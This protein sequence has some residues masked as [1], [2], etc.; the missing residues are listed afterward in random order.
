MF[1]WFYSSTCPCSPPAKDWVEYRLQWLCDEFDDHVFNGRPLVLPTAQFFPDPY[2]D[3][4]DCIRR[5]M[6]RVCGYMDVD[7]DLVDLEFVNAENA[8]WFV[9]EAGKYVPKAGGTYEWLD[10][11][12]VISL[13]LAETVDLGGMVATLSHEL[14]HARLLGEER[15]SGEEYDHELLTD[16]T[17][18]F[19][20][21]GT[22]RANSPRVWDSQYTKWPNT[23][24]NKPEYMSPPLI[25]YA[26][27]HLAWFR[28]EQKPAWAKYLH[29]NARPDFQ[30]SL[31][32]LNKTGDSEFKPPKLRQSHRR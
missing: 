16:L 1:D 31:R 23:D 17:T 24:F 21:F 30:Q 14:A 10:G 26:L 27:A 29:L 8:P 19:F 4:E 2:R 15:V 5:L 6:Y 18:I 25:G 20:G 3:T 13:D 7:A 32:F 11:R 9:N 22:F 12:H 28:G